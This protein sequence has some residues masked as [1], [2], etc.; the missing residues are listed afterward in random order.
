MISPPNSSVG[1]S[2]LEELSVQIA[3]V[4]QKISAVEKELETPADGDIKYLRK[5]KEQLRR[6]KEQLRNK[7]EQL[8][9]EKEQLRERELILLRSEEDTP[10]P[11]CGL[12]RWVFLLFIYLLNNFALAFSVSFYLGDEPFWKVLAGVAPQALN[13]TPL[14]RYISRWC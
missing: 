3:K 13:Q 4:E 11:T 7:E 1:D 2:P 14:L 8:R 9:R 10:T 12:F 5:E 6:E